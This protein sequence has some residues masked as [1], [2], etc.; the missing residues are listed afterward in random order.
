[1]SWV[2]LILLNY[3]EIALN[4]V[5]AA[6]DAL[7]TFDALTFILAVISGHYARHDFRPFVEFW[8][9]Y[10]EGIRS[11]CVES[12]CCLIDVHGWL[13]HF[14]LDRYACGRLLTRYFVTAAVEILDRKADRVGSL[15]CSGAD[16][17]VVYCQVVYA[18]NRVLR[19]VPFDRIIQVLLFFGICLFIVESCFALTEPDL[20]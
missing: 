14:G 13:P 7:I 3:H 9:V 19:G 12:S 15:G 5:V 2:L 8:L 6:Q 11:S 1:M 4:S 17:L 10:G 18:P 16:T 20:L